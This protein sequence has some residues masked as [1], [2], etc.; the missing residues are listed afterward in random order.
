MLPEISTPIVHLRTRIVKAHEPMGV[1]KQVAPPVIGTLTWNSPACDRV[2]DRR[3][4]CV[5][6]E[7]K[8][9]TLSQGQALDEMQSYIDL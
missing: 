6:Q 3:T 8:H 9:T 7:T 4:G 1:Q 2:K 5:V